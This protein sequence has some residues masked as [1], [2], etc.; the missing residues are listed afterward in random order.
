MK[1]QPICAA[2]VKNLRSE[3]KPSYKLA[4]RLIKKSKL[5]GVLSAPQMRH[6]ARGLA[7]G[8]MTK[9]EVQNIYK[10]HAA[11]MKRGRKTISIPGKRTQVGVVA[12]EFM[13]LTKFTK[14]QDADWQKFQRTGSL[15]GIHLGFAPKGSCSPND[16]AFI[17]GG[18]IVCVDFGPK[19]S[20]RYVSSVE[21]RLS[22][23]FWM[24]KGNFIKIGPVFSWPT[25]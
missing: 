16:G 11:E 23:K 7:D 9:A 13:K 18:R 15:I 21:L 22:G 3:K 1:I 12:R 4:L 2:I 24:G 17:V 25:K 19:P 6:L 10:K 14:E 5:A 8:K 20:E